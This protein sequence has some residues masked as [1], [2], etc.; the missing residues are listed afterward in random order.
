V[1]SKRGKVGHP[2]PGVAVRIVNP[3]T[4]EPVPLGQPGLLLVRGPNIM[5]GYLGQPEKTAEVLRDGWYT[6]GDMAFLDEDGFLEITDRL[7]RFSK[8]GGEMV[9][10]MKVEEVLQDLASASEQVFAVTGVPDS[11]KGERLVV[12]HTLSEEQLQPCLEKLSSAGLPNLWTPDTRQFFRIETMPYL[13]TGKLDLRKLRELA[14][15]FS[16][17][18]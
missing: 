7:S 11:R 16:G 17:E 1:G 13:G 4:G 9:P 8:I 12:L 14:L 15:R 5:Q 2:L 10:H 3:D 18:S 6:T